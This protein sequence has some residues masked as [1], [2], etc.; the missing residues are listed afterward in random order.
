MNSIDSA[1]DF[2]SVSFV[3]FENIQTVFNAQLPEKNPRCF[4]PTQV[5]VNKTSYINFTILNNSILFD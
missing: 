5:N 2:R 3:N 1:L 4:L